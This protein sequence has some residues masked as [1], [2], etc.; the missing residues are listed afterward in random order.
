[1][2]EKIEFYKA[3]AEEINKRRRELGDSAKNLS[4]EELLDNTKFSDAKLI[5]ANLE[6]S[7]V[8]GTKKTDEDTYKKYR[9]EI[10]AKATGKMKRSK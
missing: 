9:D 7:S 6:T 2:E 4:D 1:L 3:N 5:Q 10:D 8:I